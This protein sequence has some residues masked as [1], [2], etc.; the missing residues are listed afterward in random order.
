MLTEQADR[1][2]VRKRWAVARRLT[3]I[4]RRMRLERRGTD[5]VG[6]KDQGRSRA[7]RENQTCAVREMKTKGGAG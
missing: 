5:L 2:L 3:L 7:D 6:A 1:G 4:W